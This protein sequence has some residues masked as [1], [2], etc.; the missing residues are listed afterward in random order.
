MIKLIITG[1][2]FS[3]NQQYVQRKGRG[4]RYLTSE[5]RA[6]GDS[7][8]WQAKAQYKRKVLT[9]DLEV[10]YH[11][12]FANKKKRDHLNF[13]KRLNDMLNQIVWQD[14]SQILISHH[15]THYDKNNLRIELII[16]E[17]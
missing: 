4:R 14:D 1:A 5:A 11:Y 3:L 13:N 12:Y 10:I 16:K 9:G 7:V 15:Y 8:G 6:Y 17:I 2:P